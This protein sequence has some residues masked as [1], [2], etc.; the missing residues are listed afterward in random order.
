MIW[1]I[2]YIIIGFIVGAVFAFYNKDTPKLDCTDDVE[3]GFFGLLWLPMLCVVI[4]AVLMSLPAW[5]VKFL[6]KR[7]KK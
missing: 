1:I 5:S 4:C 6:Y 2:C 3:A 7:F